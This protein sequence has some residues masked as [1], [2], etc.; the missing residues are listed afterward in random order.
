MK[1][2]TLPEVIRYF[3]PMQ[4]LRD[5]GLIDW[6]IDR[7]GNP[8]DSMQIYLQGL[9]LA[10]M[11]V[12]VLFTGHTGSGK[13]TALNKLAEGLKRQFFI[14]PFEVREWAS[15]SDL[16]YVDLLLGMAMSLFKRAS[17]PEVLG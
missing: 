3:N 8:L 5:Q 16:N 12:K 1:A 13:S 10:D 14:V 17:E 4:P 7:P 9:A 11:P 15:I 2:T 6:Y